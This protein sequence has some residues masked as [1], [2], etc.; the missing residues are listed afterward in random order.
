MNAVLFHFL[1]YNLCFELTSAHIATLATNTHT[2]NIRDTSILA[3]KKEPL[4]SK[5]SPA[6]ANHLN[7][8]KRNQ[9]HSSKTDNNS[10]KYIWQLS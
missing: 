10:S 3:R 2:R 7:D 1:L 8:A 4:K 6:A 9:S 5:I